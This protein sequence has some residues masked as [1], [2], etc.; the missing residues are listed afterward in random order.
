[1]ALKQYLKTAEVVKNGAKTGLKLHKQQI[2][3]YANTEA[4]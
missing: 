4:E 1:M 2:P 3:S